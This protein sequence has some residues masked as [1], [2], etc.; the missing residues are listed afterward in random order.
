MT[1]HTYDLGRLINILNIFSRECEIAAQI[2]P[3][4]FSGENKKRADSV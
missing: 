4:V 3:K 1:F 2:I